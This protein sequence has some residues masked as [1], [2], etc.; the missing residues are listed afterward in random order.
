MNK[1]AIIAVTYN[2]I[3]SLT[4]LLKSLENAEYGDERPTLIISIDKS[5][6]DAVEKF[7]DDYHW[8]HGERIV[9]KHEKNLGLRNHMMS[10]GEWFEKFDTLIILEDDL[11]VSPCFYTYTR[12]ASDKYMDSKEVCGISLYSFSCNYLT[13]TSFI[14][15]KNEYDGYFMNC[16]MSWGEVWMKPQWNEF[17]AWYLEH[18]EFTSEPHLPEIICCWS[19]SWLKYHS[20]YCI[21][22]DKYFL[23]P[24]V[25]L[26][27]N[28]TE[29]GEHSSEDVSYIFQTTLQQGKKTDFSF[30]D[31]A[32]EAVCYDGFFENKAIYK[33]LGLSEEECCVDINGTKGNRQKRRFWLTSQ[34]V[35]L[36][37]VKSF[38]LTYRPVE[39]GVIDRVEGEEI[40]LYDTDCTE[41][42][43]GVSG[44]TYLYTASLESGLSVIR[45]YGLKNFLK[46]LCNRF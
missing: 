20:R 38:A 16:A 40:F 15:V 2:R 17:H 9:R 27:T 8:P 29:Q 3:D 19:K 41:Q 4:R 33:S 36:P 25:S 45:K 22:T 31:S 43:Y 34:K 18:Q 39:M 23:H 1:I 12:Q 5:K 28:Y 26:T 6:T 46:E 21:E 30:P 42:K 13:R 14:P 7:A 32:E 37:K 44:V 24:Y 11:V 10:L 35:K